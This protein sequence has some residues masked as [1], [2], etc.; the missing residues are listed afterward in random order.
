MLYGFLEDVS[1]AGSNTTAM[2]LAFSRNI[3]SLDRSYALN[4]PPTTLLTQ[5]IHNKI[6]LSLMKHIQ[7]SIYPQ[8]YH[9]NKLT[10]NLIKQPYGCLKDTSIIIFVKI[11]CI[12]NPPAT[13]RCKSISDVIM[14]HNNYQSNKLFEKHL[15]GQCNMI[16]G[17]GSQQC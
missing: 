14:Q 11:Q 8:E 17:K 10:L 13:G 7:Q 15:N 4:S 6:S 1:H 2:S 16:K 3:L 5:N 9:N 12:G